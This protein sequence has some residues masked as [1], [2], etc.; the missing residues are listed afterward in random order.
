[1]A[2]ED[3][4]DIVRGYSDS[5]YWFR[6][7]VQSGEPRRWLLDVP[8]PRMDEVQFYAPTGDGNYALTRAGDS[9]APDARPIA[10]RNLVFPLETAAEP[11]TFYLRVSTQGTINLHAVL[12]TTEDFI[13]QSQTE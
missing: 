8:Y 2:A 1:P 6:F 3:G 9:V 12:R 10:H 7:T 5:V 11:R 4:R 13:A